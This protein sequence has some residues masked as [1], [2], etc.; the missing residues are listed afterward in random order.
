MCRATASGTSPG[1]RRLR[2]P[3]GA[4]RRSRTPAPWARRPA[5]CSAHGWCRDSRHAASVDHTPG[6]LRQRVT[7]RRR[8]VSRP[9]HHDEMA[10][11]ENLRKRLPRADLPK[12]VGADDE[13]GGPRVDAARRATAPASCSV[14]DG[15]FDSHLQVGDAQSRRGPAR[16]GPPWR[17]GGRPRRAGAARCGGTL[18][19]TSS[20]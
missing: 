12:R 5:R 11:V 4:G 10:P 16:P 17:T 20:M 14:Y 15:S 13:T 1:D 6:Q 8:R 2:P 18:A 19:G 9:G 7:K 3:R